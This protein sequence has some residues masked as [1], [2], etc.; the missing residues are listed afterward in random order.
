MSTRKDS[1]RDR[2]GNGDAIT[3]DK[4]SYRERDGYRADTYRDDIE[5]SPRD[6]EREIDHTRAHMERTLDL[7]ERKLSPGEMID[8][9]IGM[10]RR[11]GGGFA[12]NLFTEVRNK[13]LPTLLAGVGITWLMSA[14]DRPPQYRGAA[15]YRQRAGSMAQGAHD[16]G[17]Q[18]RQGA[19]ELGERAQEM[20]AQARQGAHDLG[21]RAQEMGAQ[22]RE[23]AR[24]MGE[25]ASE[26]G[27]RAGEAASE[28]GHRMHEM[29]DEARGAMRRGGR[30]AVDEYQQLLHEQPLLL[31]GLGLALGAAVGSM[32]PR[33]DTENRVMGKHS[34]R[35]KRQAAE[36]GRERYEDMRASAERVAGAAQ[37]QAA[38]EQQS[39]N[40]GGRQGS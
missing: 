34:D 32:L 24:H 38:R 17:A 11:N 40:G 26:L 20:G 3:D 21:E 1:V 27:H 35:I 12:Q 15:M 23:G 13:P 8:E 16:M 22:A 19:H 39:H 7:L 10:I 2:S 4:D 30:R 5:K 33:T 29:A 18:A 25:R 9:V 6:L 37:E 36:E 14:S 28:A 31:A